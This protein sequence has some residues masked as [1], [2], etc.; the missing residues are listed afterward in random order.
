MYFKMVKF[1]DL[2]SNFWFG[3]N[4]SR[5][6]PGGREKN[7][8]KFLFS[9]FFVVP[10]NVLW[11]GLWRFYEGFMQNKSMD[12]FLYDDG[13]RHERVKGYLEYLSYLEYLPFSQKSIFCS[14]DVYPASTLRPS[15]VRVTYWKGFNYMF[16]FYFWN[17]ILPSFYHQFTFLEF[18]H[19]FNYPFSNF[20]CFSLKILKVTFPVP[21]FQYSKCVDVFEIRFSKLFLF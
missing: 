18:S 4:S 1:H 13:L 14:K 12:W 21:R 6:N 8:V 16:I 9:H 7:Y 20:S 5:P 2:I 3:F 15:K 19:S 10:Q 11:R 17:F